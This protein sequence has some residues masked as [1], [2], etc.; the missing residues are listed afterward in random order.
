LAS[1]HALLGVVAIGIC[2]LAFLAIL[3][4]FGEFYGGTW[5]IVAQGVAKFTIV[6][7]VFA[8]AVYVAVYL[9]GRR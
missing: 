3:L 9:A 6:I 8:L 5:Q 1:D 7:T 4:A 2:I